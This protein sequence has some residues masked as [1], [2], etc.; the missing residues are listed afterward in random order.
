MGQLKEILETACKYLIKCLRRC[1]RLIIIAIIWTIR[2]I[3]IF[4]VWM[5][6]RLRMA[7]RWTK[8][9][10]RMAWAWT[11]WAVK[12]AWAWTKWG[13]KVAV[14]YIVKWW[15]QTRKWC[16]MKREQIDDFRRNK[17][18]KE[19]LTDAKSGMKSAVINYVDDKKEDND[20][21]AEEEVE[22][23]EEEDKDHDRYG[24]KTLDK[25]NDILKQIVE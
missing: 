8:K 7:W 3:R 19:L 20:S 2:E 9:A 1:L 24:Q 13:C 5:K 11:K 17:S 16:G 25:I 18:M 15:L 14:Y 23:I 10:T 21:N 22:I 6:P 12:A 4:S